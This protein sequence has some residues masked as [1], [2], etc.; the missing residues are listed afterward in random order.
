MEGSG[1]VLSVITG[2]EFAPGSGVR[3]YVCF[4]VQARPTRIATEMDK[5]KLRHY[6]E[7]RMHC[8]GFR[9]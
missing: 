6:N 7:T 3:G 9:V 2:V 8:L 5:Y 4:Q 1:F